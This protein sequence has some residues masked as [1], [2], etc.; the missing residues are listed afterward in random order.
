M[1]TVYDSVVKFEKWER[2]QRGRIS[3]KQY[4][5]APP[6]RV[7]WTSVKHNGLRPRYI[8]Q[9]TLALA[10]FD[11]HSKNTGKIRQ[12]HRQSEIPNY[13]HE[14]WKRLLKR[15]NENRGNNDNGMPN[16]YSLSV[17]VETG[18]EMAWACHPSKSLV[19]L[20]DT[21]ESSGSLLRMRRRRE[22]QNIGRTA[23]YR[24]IAVIADRLPMYTGEHARRH[25]WQ[26]CI[27]GGR[28]R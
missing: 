21:N 3:W 10:F 1:I 23:R 16:A 27:C 13:N 25:L 12:R 4:Y 2:L 17:N 5:L 6:S 19:H 28:Q 9:A 8:E 7:V 15:H 20:R 24:S 18:A 14:I 22:V 11:K 26:L